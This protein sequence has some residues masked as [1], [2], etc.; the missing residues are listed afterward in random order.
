M[1]DIGLLDHA[2]LAVILT[3]CGIYIMRHLKRMFSLDA[4][5]SKCSHCPGG[6][7]CPQ[8]AGRQAREKNCLGE[9]SNT[10]LASLG[11]AGR[12]F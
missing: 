10:G 11:Q 7:A 12:P 6:E 2:V 5:R 1:S 3:F 9:D 8:T 4:N